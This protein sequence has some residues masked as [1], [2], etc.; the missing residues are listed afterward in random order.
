MT[1]GI[2]VKR[3]AGLQIE[4]L[5]VLILRQAILALSLLIQSRVGSIPVFTIHLF[6]QV[7][8]VT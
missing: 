2:S 4:N 8:V 7:D 1:F 6:D 5:W 3:I